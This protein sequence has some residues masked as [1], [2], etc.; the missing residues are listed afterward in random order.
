MTALTALK[1][2]VLAPS[3]CKVFLKWYRK[4]TVLYIYLIGFIQILANRKIT[5]VEYFCYL[6][7]LNYQSTSGCVN[8]HEE[9]TFLRV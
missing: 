4:Y 6:N 2:P 9:V 5:F 3:L 7:C 1:K 8:S